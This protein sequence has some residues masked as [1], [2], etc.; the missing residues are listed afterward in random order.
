MLTFSASHCCRASSLPCSSIIQCTRFPLLAPSLTSF[1]V[2]KET[3]PWIFTRNLAGHS[4]W[5]NIKHRKGIADRKRAQLFMK[6]S[7][8]I[9]TACRTGKS[10]DIDVNTHL[11]TAINAAKA[12]DMPNNKIEA[13]LR[14]GAGL[15]SDYQKLKFEIAG[16]GGS[17]FLVF[18]E[19][20]KRDHV[21]P[22][23]RRVTNKYGGSIGKDGSAMWAFRHLGYVEIDVADDLDIEELAIDLDADD[24]EIVEHDEPNNNNDVSTTIQYRIVCKPSDVTRIS[25]E[26][27]NRNIPI[28][29]SDHIYEPLVTAQ[30]TETELAEIK[31]LLGRLEECE[32]VTHVVINLP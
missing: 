9:I 16:P 28:L 13:A 11:K 27:Q 8:A 15:D 2:D 4:K 29:A 23:I 30:P 24:V 5:A 22:D 19:A 32:Y 3:L 1:Q 10:T 21:L 6:L 25:Q 31:I 14:V 12:S 17:Q 7:R 20:A 26:L 18:A